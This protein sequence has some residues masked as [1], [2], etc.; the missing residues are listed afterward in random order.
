M[1]AGETDQT[2]DFELG[3]DVAAYRAAQRRRAADAT[4][5]AAIPDQAEE[6]RAGGDHATPG[7]GRGGP[8]VQFLVSLP[9]FLS[10]GSLPHLVLTGFIGI[11]AGLPSSSDTSFKLLR[12]AAWL[13]L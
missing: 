7:D 3:S 1:A 11:T 9:P 5:D 4:P 6:R 13:L 12:A 2:R 8:G 10:S